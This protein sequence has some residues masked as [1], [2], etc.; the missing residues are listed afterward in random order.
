MII[1]P[2]QSAP[3]VT[4]QPKINIK[5]IYPN[6]ENLPPAIVTKKTECRKQE[7]YS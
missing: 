7:T 4:K 5:D 1:R 2:G 6:P 3:Y